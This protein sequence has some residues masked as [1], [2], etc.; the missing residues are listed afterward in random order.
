MGDHVPGLSIVFMGFAALAGIAIPVALLLIFRKRFKAD[1]L[2]FFIGC[3]VFVVFALVVEGT[4]HRL[5]LPTA[6]GKALQGNIW[7]YAVYGG[8]MAGLF[9]ESGRFVAFKTVLRRKR[10]NNANAL[11]YGAG[12]GG[13]EV[14]YLLG[15]TMI[16]SLVMSVMLNAGMA[17]KL[18]AGVTGPEA[19]SQLNATFTALS[20]TAPPLFLVGV[21]ERLAAVALHISLSVLVWF[22]AKNNKRF[23]LYP[24]AVLLHALVDAIAVILAHY[25]VNVWII[26]G[27]VYVMSAACAVLAVAVWKRNKDASQGEAPAENPEQKTGE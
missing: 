8:L 25:G 9:E 23:W 12:H 5:F 14:F 26:E 27:L 1:I 18:T 3:V 24:L 11:M 6:L 15:V 4:I 2:P 7:L 20:K 22:G 10:G 16:S 21:V 13:F 17:D 19:L